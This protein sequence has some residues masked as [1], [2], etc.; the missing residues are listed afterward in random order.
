MKS[1]PA[2]F[3][4][5]KALI[6]DD[7][8]NVLKLLANE[9]DNKNVNYLVA[10]NAAEAQEILN[11]N[12]DVTDICYSKLVQNNKII[13]PSGEHNRANYFSDPII[14]TLKVIIINYNGNETSYEYN[15]T[16]EINLDNYDIVTINDYKDEEK[17]SN[18][19]SFQ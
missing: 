18:I 17:L 16:I 3:F 12:I 8:P 1:I 10:S 13:I 7:D 2:I 9:L 15:Y 5:V 11:K 6:V 4:P 19:H 14:G